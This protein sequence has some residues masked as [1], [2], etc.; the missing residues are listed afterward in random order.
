M[1]QIL[2]IW[3]IGSLYDHKLIPQIFLQ[4]YENNFRF[5]GRTKYII[6]Y[7]PLQPPNPPPLL[8]LSYTQP[9][10]PLPCEAV[11]K[12]LSADGTVHIV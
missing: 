2:E 1:T 11:L 9:R 12:L 4:Y 5:C 3:Y 10:S 6:Y 7:I 8:E